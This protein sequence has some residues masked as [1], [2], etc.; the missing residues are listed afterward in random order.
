MI[1]VLSIAG[2]DPSGG[3]GIQADIKTI[4]ALGGYAAAVI[5]AVTAQNTWGVQA[6][7][8]LPAD[9]V[10]KQIESVMDDLQPEAIKIGMVHDTTIV[11]VIAECLRKYRPTF[12]VYDP[13]MVSTS[14]RRLMTEDT[15]QSICR[16]LFPLCT[17]IT[18]NLS[19]AEMLSG[20]SIANPDEMERT[21]EE[22]SRQ[23]HTSILLKGGHLE[24]TTMC[25]VLHHQGNTIRYA[26]PKVESRNL[27]GTGCTLSSAIATFLSMGHTLETSVRL[28]KEYVHQAIEN[29]RELS[30]GHGNGPLWHFPL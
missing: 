13:V 3:A 18:P 23:Y 2:S 22:L 5:T 8:P 25:D 21:S 19:E 11:Q 1:K 14:G 15:M 29:G 6:V 4:S 30:I 7:Y 12:I 28:S 9:I 24:G 17:L 16:E 26:A 10:R 27:H 20:H